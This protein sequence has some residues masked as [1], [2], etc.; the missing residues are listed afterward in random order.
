MQENMQASLP[1][2]SNTP[3]F[4][5]WQCSLTPHSSINK[6]SHRLLLSARQLS[7]QFFVATRHPVCSCLPFFAKCGGAVRIFGKRTW[8]YGSNTPVNIGRTISRATAYLVHSQGVEPTVLIATLVLTMV[9]PICSSVSHR[10][11]SNGSGLCFDP[12]HS[13]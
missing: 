12:A 13:N 8:F 11:R 7:T 9:L 5:R 3:P 2:S 4:L 10:T 6:L 1:S